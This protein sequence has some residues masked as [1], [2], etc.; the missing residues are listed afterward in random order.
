MDTWAASVTRSPLSNVIH[1]QAGRQW[2]NAGRLGS[3]LLCN[4]LTRTLHSLDLGRSLDLG[5]PK[6]LILQS[7]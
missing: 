5:Y 7:H 3:L 4:T 2:D 6:D 1:T